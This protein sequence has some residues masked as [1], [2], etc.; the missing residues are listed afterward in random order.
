MKTKKLLALVLASAMMLGALTACGGE[1]GSSNNAGANTAA[2]TAKTDDGAGAAAGDGPAC[3]T[4][5]CPR[6]RRCDAAAPLMG[7]RA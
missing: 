5:G 7:Q 4:Y 2:S 3:G 1:S 6:C